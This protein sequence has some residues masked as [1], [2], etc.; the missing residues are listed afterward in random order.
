MYGHNGL[1]YLHFFFQTR[2][3]LK[4]LNA[5]ILLRKKKKNIYKINSITENTL[6]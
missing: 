1:M 6:K 4:I 2:I 3:L 5:R